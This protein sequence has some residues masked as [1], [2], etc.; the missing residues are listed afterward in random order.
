MVN[1]T[2]ATTKSTVLGIRLD[3]D[4]RAWIE[5]EAARRGV[6][7][8]G[9]FEGMIDQ[10]R[11]GQT[12][13]EAPDAAGPGSA[14]RPTAGVPTRPSSPSASSPWPDLGSMTVLP[15]GMVRGAVSITTGLIKSGGRYARSRVEHCPLKQLW[16]ERWV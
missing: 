6:S 8:R 13:D 15:C 11:T 5:A 16:S 3:H 7:V 1:A 14:S 10:A 12:V 4:R 2:M 9:L